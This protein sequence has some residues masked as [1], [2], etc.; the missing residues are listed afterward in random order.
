MSVLLEPRTGL[1]GTFHLELTDEERS[2]VRGL[3]EEVAKAEPGL[4]DDPRWL[5]EARRLSCRLPVR[6]LET[7]R[8]FRHDAG[9]AGILMLSG[10]P[11]DEELLPDTP[12]VRDSVERTPEIP[13]AVAMLLGQQLGEI[14]A[15]RDEK[16]G[17]LVQN[18]VP[19]QALANS[20]SNA[21]SVLLEL[22]N[23]NAFHPR[24]PDHIGL[25]C[26]R[27]DH[28]QRAGTLVSC[29]RDALP[30]LDEAD[31]AILNS[32]RFVTE[33]PPSFGAGEAT[34]PHPVLGGSVQDPDLQVD[35]NA[36]AALDDEAREALERLGVALLKAS[37][38]LVLRPG[39]MVFVDNRLVVHGRTDF[40]PRY[41]G[42]DRWL[43]RI[44]V[45]LDSRR[46]NAYRVDR[47]SVLV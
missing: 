46:S 30:L 39:E 6:L 18:V 29:V 17:A 33:A 14:V 13:A 2:G 31:V 10:L 9:Q 8:Q 44:Y 22:H 23:E 41:D 25:M 19:V 37:S 24:R 36:T 4:L 5:A 3:A 11:V 38:S 35:F 42:R 16:Q 20:Q 47:G 26:L 45:Q 32:P 27:S 7:L 1:A 15:Y 12:T 43:H 21:G 40:T 34:A 28:E